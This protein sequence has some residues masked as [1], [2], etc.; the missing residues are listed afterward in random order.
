VKNWVKYVSKTTEIIRI[1][2]CCCCCCCIT[3]DVKHS[4]NSTLTYCVETHLNRRTL[5]AQSCYPAKRFLEATQIKLA[6]HTNGQVLHQ[7]QVTG[8]TLTMYY[9]G[10]FYRKT[11]SRTAG[12]IVAANTPMMPPVLQGSVP[13]RSALKGNSL[14]ITVR[15]YFFI[16]NVTQHKLLLI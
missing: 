5:P 12:D 14:Y 10:C 11:A 15:K 3:Y 4:K 13:L 2:H 1:D 8:R 16:Y 7:S 6:L 9:T